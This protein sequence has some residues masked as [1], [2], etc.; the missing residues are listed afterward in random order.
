MPDRIANLFGEI[1]HLNRKNQYNPNVGRFQKRQ[2]NLAGNSRH[3]VYENQIYALNKN[4]INNGVQ[5]RGVINRNNDDI[6]L[7][8]IRKFSENHEVLKRQKELRSSHLDITG[9]KKLG[10]GSFGAVCG[11]KDKNYVVF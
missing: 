5:S 10:E 6:K 2:I 9:G 8:N 4:L 11:L 1:N 3:K 7:Q